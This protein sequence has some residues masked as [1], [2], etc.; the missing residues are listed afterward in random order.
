MR[1]AMMRRRPLPGSI[2]VEQPRCGD[3]VSPLRPLH[4]AL[5]GRSALRRVLQEGGPADA[6]RGW[7]ADLSRSGAGFLS[8]ASHDAEKWAKRSA[9][10]TECECPVSENHADKPCDHS[11]PSVRLRP[12]MRPESPLVA[13]LSRRPLLCLRSHR[14]TV[15]SPPRHG[16]RA[17][18]ADSRRSQHAA[19]ERSRTAV[20]SATM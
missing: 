8:H 4:P 5:Q 16:W 19:D 14:Q 17:G 6:C 20:I 9:R 3:P 10:S 12:G 13:R 11:W 15:A 1:C 2:G 18:H 7:K